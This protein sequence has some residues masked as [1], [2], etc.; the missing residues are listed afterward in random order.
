MMAMDGSGMG[1]GGGSPPEAAPPELVPQ[2]EPAFNAPWPALLI[3]ALILLLYALQST[4]G[5]H[6]SLIKAFGFA[7]V[8]LKEGRYLPL[9]TALFVHGSWTHALLNGLGALAFGAPVARLMGL[10]LRGVLVFY[11]FY[12]LCGV[13]AGVGF[14]WLH[15]DAEVLLVGASGA[16]SGLMGAASRL[17]DRRAA[18]RNGGLAPFRNG[19]VMSMALAWLVINALAAVVGFGVISGDAPI[20]WEAHLFGYAAG[21]LLVEPAWRVLAGGRSFA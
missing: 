20:A 1:P 12:L 3:A 13:V 10:G 2:R 5:V 16:V 21:L 7:P 14:A 9:V 11:L 6:D 8:D 4:S 19:T 18:M 17:I 15:P